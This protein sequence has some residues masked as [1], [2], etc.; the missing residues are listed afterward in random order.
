MDLG[1]GSVIG[2][3]SILRGKGGEVALALLVCGMVFAALAGPAQSLHTRTQA[4]QQTAAQLPVTTKT[5][6]ATIGYA[7]MAG[8]LSDD[9]GVPNPEIS[10]DELD[11][12][13][14]EVAASLPRVPFV[15]GASFT[16]VVSAG[17]VVT[18]GYGPR[19]AGVKPPKLEFSY[20][21]S[22]TAN[23]RLVA[24]SLAPGSDVP[25]GALAVTATEATAT[26]FGLRPGSR[27]TVNGNSVVVTGIITPVDPGSVFWQFD[28]TAMVPAENN[29]QKAPQ[30]IGE[31]FA[32]PGQLLTMDSMFGTYAT[33]TW[34]YPLT[35]AAVNADQVQGLY[36]QLNRVDGLAPT[37]HG[38][39]ADFANDII[40]SSPLASPLVT[41]LQ[42]QAA[43]LAVLLLL[44]VSLG[45]IGIAVVFMAARMIVNRRQDELIMLRARGASA[46]QVGLGLA[47]SAAL[48]SVPAAAV[49]AV[50]AIA[51]VPGAG[52]SGVLGWVLAVLVIVIAVALPAGIAIWRHRRPMA[53]ANPA[54]I[55]T[56]ETRTTRFS[57]RAL[58]RIVAELSAAGAAIAGLAVL[59]GQGVTAA[60]AAGSDV[61]L[62]TNWF[63]TLAPVLVAIL[64]VLITL[65]LY[66]L[67]VRAAVRI[68]RRRAGATSY[69][70]LAASART[71][72]AT[73]GPVF[74]L[75]LALTLT[76]FCGMITESIGAAQSTVS[77][78]TT[79][80]DAVVAAENSSV[81]YASPAAERDVAAVRG[82]R[83]FA[84]VWSTAWTSPGG[85]QITV[86]AVN[87]AQYAALTATTP[88][89]AI[90][91]GALSV[92][93]R[94]VTPATTIGVLASPAAVAALGRGT[95][96][97]TSINVTGP[98][99][100]HITGTLSAAP[101][102]PSG[103]GA[104]ILMPLQ[105]LPGAGGTPQ[106]NSLLLT[107]TS[108]DRTQLAGVV[109]ATLPIFGITYRAD[110][111]ASLARSPLLHG[112]VVLMLLTALAAA[113]FALLN[114]ILGLA[115]GAADRDLTLT[116]LTVM[117]VPHGPRLAL[118]ETLPAIAAA[119]IASIVCALALPPVTANAL[120]LSVFTSSNLVSTTSTTAVPL[121]PDL[122]SVGLPAAILLVLAI[123]T[124]V[125]QTRTTRQRG[126]A[127]LLRAY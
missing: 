56:A 119:I 114:L 49:G 55:M 47:R 42:A 123:A 88:F 95:S 103:G 10:P 101:A 75:V 126:P 9:T 102:A 61:T 67:P 2:G 97:L 72:L 66:P 41:F 91:P 120:D 96:Q 73:A 85:Q 7:D 92:S 78:Q 76:A 63:L 45:A 98:I 79:G 104:W 86:V 53:A 37:L 34:V 109:A 44:F 77:W 25:A 74:A 50:A 62:S 51:T 105:T 22:L 124:L 59:R 21:D 28:V 15:A 87:P 71:S 36:N 52:R 4:F 93:P 19:A 16:S 108:I 31:V 69:V 12:A 90:P 65:R 117:G 29:P 27:L 125:L 30:W 35:L 8:D 33:V 80:A 122:I 48:A 81:T 14:D 121:Q 116:R 118:T 115:L 43:V 26:R 24:G 11:S 13:K 38:Q 20:R 127:R 68:A 17:E 5:I 57:P 23:S 3:V 89:P 6:Q 111:L 112:A 32:D 110:V 84:A 60:G 83:R 46:R 82:V 113:A 54:R 1:G 107:G 100:V 94:P 58:R 40:V 64:A 18:V 70:A 106:P 99:T 39:L